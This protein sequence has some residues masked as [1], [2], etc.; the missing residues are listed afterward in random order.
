MSTGLRIVL[1]IGLLSLFGDFVYE[2]GRSVLPDYMRQLG[3][4]AFLIGLVLGFAEFAGWAVRPLGGYI[5]DRTRKYALMVRLGYAGLIIIPL[6]GVF[7]VWWAIAIFAV[8]ERIFRGLR[9]PPRDAMLAK[10]RGNV[11]LG[12]TFGIHELL[13]QVGAAAGPLLAIAVLAAFQSTQYV[14]FFMAIPYIALLITLTRVPNYKEP[15]NIKPEIKPS[16]AVA[17]YSAA[18]GF[19]AA[20]LLPL[21]LVL[22]MVSVV[23]GEGSWLVPAAYTLAMVIDAVAGLVFGRAFDRW[24][25]SVVLTAVAVSIFPPL[26]IYSSTN[27]LMLAALLI[28]MVIGAQ[29][30]IFRAAV[31]HLSNKSGLSYAY[32]LY[33]LGLGT[34][35]AVAGIIYGCMI[36]IN[37]PIAF[38][39]LYAVVAQTAAATLLVKIF[40]MSKS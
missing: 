12:T 35:G 1:I 33:G 31:A 14:F 37:A 17:L 24:G 21:P 26:L 18:A 15:F 6:M 7:P 27:L 29:E 5:A 22:F 20:G 3:M 28:G 34:G 16:R 10:L 9:T 13:D 40:R 19:N 11:G 4:N 36:Q 30:S 25:A 8:L 32:A 2:G 23:E 38:M 39:F